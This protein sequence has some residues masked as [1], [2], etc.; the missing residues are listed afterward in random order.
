MKR[1]EGRHNN[2]NGINPNNNSGINVFKESL[3]GRSSGDI[4]YLGSFIKNPDAIKA[5]L[6][7]AKDLE[8][9][10]TKRK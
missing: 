9:L 2:L 5:A 7:P 6:T 1:W 10:A 3:S 8:V 4:Y